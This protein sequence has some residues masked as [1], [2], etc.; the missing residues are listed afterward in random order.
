MDGKIAILGRNFS[1]KNIDQDTNKN[2]EKPLVMLVD[3]E[4]ENINVLRQLLES[5]FQIITGLNGAEALKLIDNMVDPKQIQLI[6]S[7][8]RMP[9]VTGVEFL[10]QIVDKIKILKSSKT[11]QN[12]QCC[13]TE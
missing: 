12:S 4:I 10:E 1:M 2:A 6:I 7:D 11:T 13:N 5:H 8:Q 3:D 9:K